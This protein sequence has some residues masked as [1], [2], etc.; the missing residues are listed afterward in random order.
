MLRISVLRVRPH[1]LTV[2]TADFQSVNRGSIPRGATKKKTSSCM[3]SFSC[4]LLREIETG[5][6][7]ALNAKCETFPIRKSECILL[8]NTKYCLYYYLL[9][10]YY[11]GDREWYYPIWKSPLNAAYHYVAVWIRTR[12]PPSFTVMFPYH[13]RW[14]N[15]PIELHGYCD[16]SWVGLHRKSF[17]LAQLQR[18]SWGMYSGLPGPP[19]V[20]ISIGGTTTI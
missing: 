10:T 5:F 16:S 13:Q 15:E 9:L 19:I 2:R 6:A 18:S 7:D 14:R 11:W 12:I 4:V 1:R 20:P 8:I 3:M 17:D